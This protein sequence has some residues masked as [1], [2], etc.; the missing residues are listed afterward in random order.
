MILYLLNKSFE[1]I[2]IIDTYVSLIWTMRYQEAGEF[3]LYLP[4]SESLKFDC[5]QMIQREDNDEVMIIDSI[6][7]TTDE[8]SGDYYIISG[9]SFESILSRRI[10]WYET[11]IY[12]NVE[13][14][15]YRLIREN[16]IESDVPER[17]IN[18]TCAPLKNLSSTGSFVYHGETL[19]DVIVKL[20]QTYGFGFKLTPSMRFEVYTGTDRSNS[21]IFS[22]DFDNLL[23]TEYKY[24]NTRYKNA[25]LIYSEIDDD[26]FIAKSFGS[27][28]GL[29]RIETFV[30]AGTIGE[31]KNASEV[32]ASSI[33]EALEKNTANETF[34]CNVRQIY[35]Y[36]KDYFLGD[37]VKIEN[38]YGMTVNAKVIEIIENED[39][40]GYRLVPTFKAVEVV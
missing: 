33:K 2:E 3:E 13:E 8:E 37:I 36:G 5:G 29:E 1:R 14:S 9:K 7:I 24:E 22:R 16:I 12:G 26:N 27:A 30:D 19:Y 28:T 34:E 21:I 20:C 4:Y 23:S 32:L 35:E 18:I 38:K 39:E 17:Y 10:I 40:S 25:G 6:K 11:E 15:I 31:D